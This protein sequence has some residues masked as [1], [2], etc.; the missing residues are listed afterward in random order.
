MVR[1]LMQNYER[2]VFGADVGEGGPFRLFDFEIRDDLS[3]EERAEQIAE[4]EQDFVKKYNLFN[5]FTFGGS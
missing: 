5:L 3:E 4:I 2:V 1:H